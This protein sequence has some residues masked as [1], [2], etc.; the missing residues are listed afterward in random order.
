LFFVTS[1]VCF[2][3]Q[4]MRNRG[5]L[6]QIKR[7]HGQTEAA[8]KQQQEQEEDNNDTNTHSTRSK[9]EGGENGWFVKAATNRSPLANF[10]PGSC[11]Q[12]T[13][14]HET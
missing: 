10:A 5:L 11:A 9:E 1:L 12:L 14:L 6:L 7:A 4:G 13:P 3:A 2:A 8:Q